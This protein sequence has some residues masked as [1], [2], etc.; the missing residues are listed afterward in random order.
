MLQRLRELAHAISS[1][2]ISSAVG[3]GIR[4]LRAALLPL[5]DKVPI[6]LFG[7]LLVAVQ[8]R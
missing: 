6:F 4:S 3:Y 8:H 7:V 2:V 5:R 1:T